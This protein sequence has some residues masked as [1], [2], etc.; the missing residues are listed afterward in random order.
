MLSSCIRSMDLPL[1]EKDGGGWR[2]HPLF[3]GSSP[4]LDEMSCHAAVLSPGHSPHAPHTHCQEELLIVLDGE[5]ELVIADSPSTEGARA[6]PVRPGAFSYYPAG[7]HHTIRNTGTSPVTYLMFKWQSQEAKSDED[8]L[9]T[10]IFHYDDD[11]EPDGSKGFVTRKL[12]Q[13]ATSQLGRLHCH[14][15]HLSPGAG[16]EPHID[17]YDVAILTLSGRI[18]TLGQEV[19]PNSVIFYPAGQKHGMR[20]VGDAPARY[21]VFEFHAPDLDIPRRVRRY[22]R[23]LVRRV[24]GRIARTLGAQTSS[25]KQEAH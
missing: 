18:E 7:Q 20:N 8:P 11:P 10:T 3:R 4:I 5:A 16:Y 2:P 23:P 17:A 14:T 15:T 6:E 22:V 19:G 1:P 21:L 24:R 9:S 25:L 13:Q 12:F